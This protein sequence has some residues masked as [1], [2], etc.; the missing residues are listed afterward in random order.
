MSP[1]PH[2]AT[3][4]HSHPP[5]MNPHRSLAPLEQRAPRDRQ[6]DT[7][8]QRAAPQRGLAT[9][10]LVPP[11]PLLTGTPPLV[12]GCSSPHSPSVGS[13][14]TGGSGGGGSGGGAPLSSAAASFSPATER[15]A[16]PGSPQCHPGLFGDFGVSP[17]L[18]ALLPLHLL[19]VLL[20]LLVRELAE[21]VGGLWLGGS[22]FLALLG[23]CIPQVALSGL[24]QIPRVVS[25]PP[26]RR[27]TLWSRVNPPTLGSVPSALGVAS[28]LLDLWNAGEP[29][30]GWVLWEGVLGAR[31]GG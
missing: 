16:G 17:T 22:L 27:H 15:H 20:Q 25:P 10:T 1:A 5:A 24:K 7:R 4:R 19:L 9:A 14:G 12:L 30:K 26:E 2:K 21:G 13:A 11:L 6:G 28:L 8:W 31:H 29:G 3:S 18:Q 23:L